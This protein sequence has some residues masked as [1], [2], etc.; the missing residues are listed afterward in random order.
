MY[1]T[2]CLHKNVTNNLD[3]A[4]WMMSPLRLLMYLI[5]PFVLVFFSDFKVP[6]LSFSTSIPSFVLVICKSFFRKQRRTA[7]EEC[8]KARHRWWRK[9]EKEKGGGGRRKRGGG[10]RRKRGGGERRKSGEKG[11]EDEKSGKQ[12]FWAK[13]NLAFEGASKDPS[14]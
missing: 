2:Q 8:C 6:K 4:Q 10:E 5:V 12:S 13:Q 9:R 1:L 7:E 3:S 11:M 14:E